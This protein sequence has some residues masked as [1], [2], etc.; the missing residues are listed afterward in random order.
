MVPPSGPPLTEVD[1]KIG[2]L[3]EV[4]LFA[5]VTPVQLKEISQSLPMQTC[6][7]VDW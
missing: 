7:V 6:V 4:D 5:G 2:L 1:L 3:R